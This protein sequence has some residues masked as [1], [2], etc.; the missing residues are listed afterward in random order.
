MPD[1]SYPVAAL[2]VIFALTIV[3]ILI[4]VTVR[5]FMFGYV[6]KPNLMMACFSTIAIVIMKIA[7]TATNYFRELLCTKLTVSDGKLK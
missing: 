5:S 1:K 7:D 6:T 2:L 3:Y 4:R